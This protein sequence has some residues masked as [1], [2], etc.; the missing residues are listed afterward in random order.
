MGD[1]RDDTTWV[2]LELTRH[3][4]Q[5]V[6]D[7]SLADAL[8]EDLGVDAD[9]PVFIP[10]KVYSKSGKKVT[11]HLVEG[12]AFIASGLDEVDYFKLEGDK[13]L[14][15]KVMA[16]PSPSGVKVL[17][18]VSDEEV[19]DLRRQLLER[20]ASDITPRMRVRVTDGKYRGLEGQVEYVE[21]DYAVVYVELR[22]LQVVAKIP[23]VFLDATID[24]K[25]EV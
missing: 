18:T 24:Q 4:E 25:A 21:D 9:W 3:G 15:A 5:K 17:S 14:V 11:V 16:V 22:S 6:E 7:G 10:A 20:I 12:Y 13:K 8:R 23:R 19:S 1:Q 2:A